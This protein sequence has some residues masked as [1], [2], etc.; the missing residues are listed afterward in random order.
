[1]NLIEPGAESLGILLPGAIHLAK[2]IRFGESPVV[3]KV[4][5][6]AKRW[7]N[8]SVCLEYYGA[9][10]FSFICVKHKRRRGFQ[11]R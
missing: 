5:Q 4:R 11:R 9:Y 10:L 7:V 8:R 3:Q 6:T 2:R 1:M